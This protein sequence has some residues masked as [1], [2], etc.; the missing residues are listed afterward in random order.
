[1]PLLTLILVLPDI[2]E[3]RRID[4]AGLE[5][6]HHPDRISTVTHR[7]AFIDPWAREFTNMRAASLVDSWTRTG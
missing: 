7:Q 1:M 2:D 3:R 6:V 4:H 5:V